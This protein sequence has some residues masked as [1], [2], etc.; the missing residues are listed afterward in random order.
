M[1][2]TQGRQ[3]ETTNDRRFD[4]APFT[5]SWR[6]WLPDVLALN[7]PDSV[8]LPYRSVLRHSEISHDAP[9]LEPIRRMT[10]VAAALTR[11]NFHGS[12]MQYRAESIESKGTSS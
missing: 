5:S 4:L 8:N 12:P 2:G 9:V 1:L 3:F 10:A 7:T 11:V 6:A